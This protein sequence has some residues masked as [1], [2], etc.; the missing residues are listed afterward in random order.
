MTAENVVDFDKKYRSVLGGKSRTGDETEEP[1]PSVVVETLATLEPFIH[2]LWHTPSREAM[3]TSRSA[4]GID[5]HLSFA[6]PET[7]EYLGYRFFQKM[8]KPVSETTMKAVISLLSARARYEGDQHPVFSR[9]AHHDERVY[10]DLGDDRHRAVCID[11]DFLPIGW[12]V[13]ESADIP[14]R[15]RR[16]KSALALPVPVAGASLD[17]LRT[18]FPN[19]SNDDWMLIVGWLIG[20][21]QQHGGRAFLELLGGQGS[22]KSTLARYLVAL[23]DPNDVPLR[24]M[25]KSEQDL[26]ISVLWRSIAGLDNVSYVAPELADALCRLSTGAGISTRPVSYTHLTL[27]TKRIV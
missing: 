20:C 19:I 21:F 18:I 4:D 23:V 3:L 17:S 22:G 8:Q 11:P 24:S 12:K 10:V 13:I 9:I 5:T 27:P 6:S 15:F 14:V 2:E 25:P 7:A 1:K 26:L 16:S